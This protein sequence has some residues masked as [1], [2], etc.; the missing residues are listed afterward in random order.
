MGWKKDSE[1]SGG[2]KTAEGWHLYEVVR[3]MRYK[4]DGTELKNKSGDPCLL[5]IYRDEDGAEGSV[6][7]S[8]SDKARWKLARDLSRLG[9]DCD[10]LDQRGV[11]TL[12]FAQLDFAESELMGR[13]SPG[14]AQA[15]GQY[16]NI[17]L[18]PWDHVK[19]DSERERLQALTGR[20]D[21][22]PEPAPPDEDL[23][24]VREP[25]DADLAA[26]DEDDLSQLPF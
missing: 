23:P 26:G 15:N 3:C 11:G 22:T 1:G 4:K 9:V 5:V 8:I 16:M 7:Y 13:T 18:L 2:R 24:P 14:Y 25:T 19:P 21:A 10:E 12:D 20:V 6:N 17:D